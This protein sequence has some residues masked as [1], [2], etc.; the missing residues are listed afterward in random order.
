VLTKPI[1]QARLRELIAQVV[2]ARPVEDL[3]A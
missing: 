1:S 2:Q 3:S